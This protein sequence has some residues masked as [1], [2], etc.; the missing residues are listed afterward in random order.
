MEM[1]QNCENNYFLL[2]SDG[3]RT[4]Y[5]SKTYALKLYEFYHG[6]ER[7]GRRVPIA[8]GRVWV[9]TNRLLTII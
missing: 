7:R 2:F 8:L 9:N 6:R 1:Q 4:G 3:Q 5:I